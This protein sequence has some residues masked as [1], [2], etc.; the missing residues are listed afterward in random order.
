MNKSMKPKRAYA[1]SRRLESAHR[2][3]ARIL[4]IARSMFSDRGIDAVTIASLA[5]GA[6]VSVSTVYALFQSKEGVL[7]ALMEEA[8]FGD[9]YRAAVA[10]LDGVSD[11]IDQIRATARIARAI[12]EGEA[13]HLGLMRGISAFSPALRA[14]E[15]DFEEKRFALQEDRIK[16]LFVQGKAK[17]G[18]SIIEARRILWMYTSRDIYRM[19][20]QDAAWTPD[21]YERWLSLTLVAALVNPAYSESLPQE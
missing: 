10:Q 18:L 6:N 17:P 14:L 12:Y 20:V 16:A 1:A 15:R 9:R 7:R 19:L 11:G 21:R 2:T 4:S 3:R 5:T 13:S 8:L